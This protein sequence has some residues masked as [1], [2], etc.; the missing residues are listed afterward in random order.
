MTSYLYCLRGLPMAG[1]L[2]PNLGPHRFRVFRLARVRRAGGPGR[3][4][5]HDRGDIPDR[6]V[7]SLFVVVSTP[8]VQLLASIFERQEPVC[9][10]T[11]AAK[12]AVERLDER[13]A[14]VRWCRFSGQDGKLIPI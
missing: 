12:L 4:C 6:A 5:Q 7:R 10:H 1:A 2:L 14:C 9:V 11:L 8:A 13:V 3:V